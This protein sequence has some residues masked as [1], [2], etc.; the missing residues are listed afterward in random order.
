VSNWLPV[1][2]YEGLYS[3]SD[4]GEVMSWVSERLLKPNR[5]SYGY[6]R[7]SLSNADGKKSP[8]IHVLVML[9]FIGVRTKGM[10]INHKN[11]DKS[12]NRLSNLEYCTAAENKQHASRMGLCASGERNGGAKLTRQQ[13]DEI[14]GKL[15]SD[16]G[17]KIALAREYGVSRY[18]IYRIDAGTHWIG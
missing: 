4:D 3:V 1:P 11:A 12:D 8:N 6:W 10:H 2:G 9:A 14:R 7:V 13:V 17:N 5:N 16:Y 15:K 18:A